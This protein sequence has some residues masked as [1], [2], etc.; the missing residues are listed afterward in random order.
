V[1]DC[2]ANAAATAEALAP[3]LRAQAVPA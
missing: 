3:W 1:G 2:I